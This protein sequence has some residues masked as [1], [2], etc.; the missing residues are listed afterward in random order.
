MRKKKNSPYS[1]PRSF[2]EKTDF[3]SFP[4]PWLRA[5]LPHPFAPPKRLR[6]RPE[7]SQTPSPHP[8]ART[9]RKREKGT[10]RRKP[11]KQTRRKKKLFGRKKTRKQALKEQKPTHGKQTRAPPARRLVVRPR[12]RSSQPQPLGATQLGQG[13]RPPPKREGRAK[14]QARR[15][16]PQRPPH[17]PQ[18]LSTRERGDARDAGRQ[19]PKRR[20]VSLCPPTRGQGAQPRAASHAGGGFLPKSQGGVPFIR[21]SL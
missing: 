3:S 2:G 15:R 7:K 19:A 13:R 18:P 1:P 8:Q 9:R 21:L 4:H 12:P 16:Q 17:P 14:P 10:Q 6:C 20:A 5:R 11:Q